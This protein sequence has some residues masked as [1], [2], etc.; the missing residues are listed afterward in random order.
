MLPAADDPGAG[1]PLTPG[2]PPLLLS[3]PL[4]PPPPPPVPAESDSCVV[5]SDS[6]LVWPAG[7]VIC[8]LDGREA[9]A[10]P[11]CGGGGGGGG[12]GWGVCEGGGADGER[13][14]RP[15]EEEASAGAG[16]A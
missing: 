3:P 8:R 13:Y 15:G 2:V 4:K 7:S 6:V 9:L 12:A 11:C 5:L 1:N 14:M 16:N 10:V